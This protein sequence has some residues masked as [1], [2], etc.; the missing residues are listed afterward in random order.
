[1]QLNSVPQPKPPP[2]NPGVENLKGS[3]SKEP[4]SF[5]FLSTK[6]PVEEEEV[7]PEKPVRSEDIFSG[8]SNLEP[9]IDPSTVISG[10]PSATPSS[11][12]LDIMDIFSEIIKI[13]LMF[14]I[15][16]SLIIIFD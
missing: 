7:I 10:K 5:G 12:P 3:D 15:I 9:S 1:M 11:N 13:K 2:P 6:P 16:E 14:T 8:L 4:M